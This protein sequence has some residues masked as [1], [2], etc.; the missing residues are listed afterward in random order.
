MTAYSR[1]Q[2][3]VTISTIKYIRKA[4]IHIS[5]V[6]DQGWSSSVL[7][8][9]LLVAKYPDLLQARGGGSQLVRSGSKHIW[10]NLKCFGFETGSEWRKYWVL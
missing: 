4:P 9:I 5:I 6:S 8:E 2:N 3:R 1:R 7:W 10:W